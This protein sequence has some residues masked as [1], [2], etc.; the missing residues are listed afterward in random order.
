M[1]DVHGDFIWY[2]LVTTN[3]DAAQVFYGGLVGWQFADFSQENM[4]Y[5]LF[6]ADGP[7]VGGL[8]GLTKDMLDN[9]ARPM[10]AGYVAVDDVDTS[11]DAVKKA[12]GAVL[13][14]P[15]DIP[16]VGRIAFVNDPQGA[17]F[18][19]MR[20][21]SDESSES[22]AATEPKVGHCA[23]NELNTSD[24]T[25]ASD[26]YGKVFGWVK[27]DSMDM[28]PAGAYDMFK[29][30]SQRDFMF[31]GMM[32]KPDEM[33]VSLWSYYFRVANIDTAENYVKDNGGSIVYGPMEIPGGEFVFSA[34]DPQGAMFSLIGSR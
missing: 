17:P 16:E 19:L 15:W 7:P 21:T 29:N 23:W 5:E 28:G 13:L 30:G 8:M 6:S 2:E 3:S 26:F 11:V 33:P 31:G 25:A 34:I 27:S 14:E 9:G 32:K 12:G 22:F 18:Y 24:P 20:G 4:K 10:W 1:S